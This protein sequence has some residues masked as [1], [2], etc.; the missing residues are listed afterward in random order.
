LIQARLGLTGVP[1]AAWVLLAG[2]VFDNLGYG[3]FFAIL[4]LYVEGRGG[5]PGLIGI[6]GAAAMVGNLAVQAPAG[7]L[8]DRISRRLIVVASLGAYGLFFL[9]YLLPL[10]VWM[11]IGVRFVHAALG[12]FYLPAARALLADLTPPHLRATAFGHWQGSGMGGFLIGPTLGGG[13]AVLGFPIVFIGAGLAGLIGA[14]LLL[15][16]P[17]RVIPAEESSEAQPGEAVLSRILVLLLPAM[18]ASLAWFYASGAYNAMWVL[19]MTALGSTPLVAGLSLSFYSLPVV[20]LSGAGGRLADR[21]GIRLLV[22]ATLV[23]T[24]VFALFYALTR[25]I[26]LVMGLG[27]AEA[28]FTV[29]GMPAI[30]AEISRAVPSR[31]QGRAQGIFGFF[32]IGIQALGS[33]AGGFLF[34]YWIVLPFVS[35]AAVCLLALVAIP[36]LGRRRSPEPAVAC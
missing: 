24:G 4:P 26:P 18:I 6:I 15:G 36:F 1:R 5:N 28:L 7:W 27:F 9:T 32:T 25:S 20:L 2:N 31:L 8:A 19:Y 35:I 14:V 29:G 30:Y 22:F 12:G 21:Y 13:L 16:L 34:G 11:L 17:L 3:M 33:L 23:G 10:P